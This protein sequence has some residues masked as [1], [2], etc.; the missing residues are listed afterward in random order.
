MSHEMMTRRYHRKTASPQQPSL[1]TGKRLSIVVLGAHSHNMTGL[2]ALVANTILLGGTVTAQVA[3]L[4]TVV[5]LLALGA[6][7]RHVSVTTTGVAGLSAAAL[8][9]VG[10]SATVAALATIGSTATT[11]TTTT[12]VGAVASNVSDL[13]AF[14]ALSSSG[15]AAEGTT[16]TTTLLG[17]R[18]VT[19][20]GQMANFTAFIARLLLRSLLAFTAQM[21]ILTAVVANGVAA[22]RALASLMTALATIVAS[23]TANGTAAIV[24]IRTVGIH[25]AGVVQVSKLN[26]GSWKLRFDEQTSKHTNSMMEGRT[27]RNHDRL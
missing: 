26:N 20:A 24:I 14:V 18:I 16:T 12:T 3:D 9:S 23:T 27:K 4:T 6:V 10:R 5:A 1:Q 17:T 8:S 22:L 7:T 2:L 21:A 13:T 15:G 11:T 19:L 25:K